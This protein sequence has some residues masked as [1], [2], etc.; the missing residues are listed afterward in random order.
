MSLKLII[1]AIIFVLT[2][3]AFFTDYFKK[4]KLLTFLAAIMA[5]I[6]TLFL[7]KDIISTL[8]DDVI[9]SLNT[10]E[11][12]IQSTDKGFSDSL[13]G[14]SSFVN[15]SI[16]LES[17]ECINTED[18]IGNDDVVL[19]NGKNEIIWMESMNDGEEK[20][21]NLLYKTSINLSLYEK[22]ASFWGDEDDYLGSNTIEASNDSNKQGSQAIYFDKDGAVYKLNYRIGEK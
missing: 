9:A 1:L 2:S 14:G 19:K 10:N 13:S 18:L 4:H 17:I 5:I 21:L 3:G 7:F 20:P 6:G 16:F 15:D 11:T 8:K 22:D 12:Q